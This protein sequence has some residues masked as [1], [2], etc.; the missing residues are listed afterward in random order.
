MAEG[1]NDQTSAATRL[2]QALH[3]VHPVHGAVVPGI[4]PASTFARDGEYAPMDGK[5]YGRDGS[6]TTDQAEKILNSVEGGAG[7]M[8][9]TS[10]MSAIVALFETLKAGDHIA[11]PVVMY[12]GT[13]TWLNRMAEMRGIEATFFDSTQEGALEAALRPGQTRML[14]IESPTNPNWD[15]I[16]IAAATDAAHAAG[17]LLIADCTVTPPVTTKALSFGAD[18]VFHSATKY[19]NGHSD[20]TAGALITRE[21]GPLWDDIRAVRV[22]Q[23]TALPAFESWL[24][25]RGMRTLALRFERCSSNAMAIAQHFEG[26]PRIAAVLYPG[27]DSHPGHAIASK[28]MR[29]GYGGML[30]LLA[31]GGEDHARR[32]ATRCKVFLPATSLGGVESLIEHRIAVEGPHSVVA[33]NLL[34]LSVGIEDVADLIADL[35]QALA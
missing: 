5:L 32:I 9:F 24:L 6:P 12:H 28:Q 11:A 18:I 17:A 33:P 2:A 27:L 10:G 14:W 8:L 34:R 4:E 16:D 25:I 31:A 3:Y 19:L 35:E 15:V 29:A 7:A 26:H 21:A 22:L 1:K 13:A 20:I 23:G 30:S